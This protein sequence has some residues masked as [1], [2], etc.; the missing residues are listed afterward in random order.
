MESL[1]TEKGGNTV[2][3]DRFSL[4]GKVAVVT[5]ATGAFGIKNLNLFVVGIG[6]SD[7]DSQT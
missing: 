7:T 5:G 3:E 2:M 6:L 4:C 1:C